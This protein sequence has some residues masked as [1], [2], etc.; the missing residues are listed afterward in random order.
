MSKLKKIIQIFIK[1]VWVYKLDRAVT[2]KTRLRPTKKISNDWF[3]LDTDGT[4]TIVA[5]YA[6]NGATPTFSILDLFTIGVPDG[7]RDYRTGL[8]LLY[9]PTLKHDCF[10]QFYKELAEV[11]VTTRHIDNEF[12]VDMQ[13][14]NFSLAKPYWKVVRLASKL[15][16][17]V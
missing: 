11:G 16:G 13:L 1:P 6:W 8:P 12:H 14:L 10:T 2:L 15:K 4:V 5:E 3:S 7:I 17:R 9:L